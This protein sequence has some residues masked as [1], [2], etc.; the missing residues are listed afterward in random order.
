[1]LI[2]KSRAALSRYGHQLVIGNDLHRRKY[3]VV[4]VER[5]QQSSPS[6]PQKGAGDQRLV[7]P[8]TPPVS[9]VEVDGDKLFKSAEEY[10][11]TW[12]RLADAPKTCVNG[13]M[14]IE[15]VIIRELLERHTKW[16]EAGK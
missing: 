2:P 6:A 14:E 1:M 11:E 10:K 16:I 9:E 12:I 8:Q 15:E 3:E 13:E 7:G 4:F 5:K